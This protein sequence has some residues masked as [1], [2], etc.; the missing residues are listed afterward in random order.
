MHQLV[1]NSKIGEVGATIRRKLNVNK[2]EPE[3]GGSRLLEKI[4]VEG[5]RGADG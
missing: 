5:R 4:F 1:P 2:K 3:A